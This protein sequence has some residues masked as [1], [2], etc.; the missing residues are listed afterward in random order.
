[1]EE[2]LS[3]GSLVGVEYSFGLEVII[4]L[5]VKECYLKVVEG[6]Y[7]LLFALHQ[8]A[9]LLLALHS[10]SLVLLDSGSLGYSRP[11]GWHCRHAKQNCHLVQV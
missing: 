9:W 7:S 8:N 11:D 6:Q 5:E 2:A 10:T 1:M 3:S 4:G